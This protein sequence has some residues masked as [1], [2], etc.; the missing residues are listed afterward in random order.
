MPPKKFT[1]KSFYAVTDYRF[2][3]PLRDSQPEPGIGR[4][5]WVDIEDKHRRHKLFAMLE[6]LLKLTRMP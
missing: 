1:E 4:G 2:P 6:D 5:C 3:H